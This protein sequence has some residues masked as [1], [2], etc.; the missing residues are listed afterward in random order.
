MNL[1]TGEYLRVYVL[2]LSGVRG[3]MGTHYRCQIINCRNVLHCLTVCCVPLAQPS[4]C[5][6]VCVCVY[7]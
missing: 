7:T 5:V 4:V 2:S 1:R 3:V 6:C